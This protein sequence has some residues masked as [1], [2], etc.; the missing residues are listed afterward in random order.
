[1]FRLWIGWG[2]GEF[3]RRGH[4][5]TESFKLLKLSEGRKH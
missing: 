4:R 1:M 3:Y 2:E 5:D